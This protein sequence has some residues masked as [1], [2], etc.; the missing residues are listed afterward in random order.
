M[1]WGRVG[2]ERRREGVE[3]F[4]V[5]YGTKVLPHSNTRPRPNSNTLTSGS[6]RYGNRPPSATD[7]PAAPSSS[8]S[9]PTAKPDVI[10]RFT[11]FVPSCEPSDS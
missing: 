8:T 4:W 2:F 9:P 11:S 10:W 7:A 1:G 6:K 3:G 5:P